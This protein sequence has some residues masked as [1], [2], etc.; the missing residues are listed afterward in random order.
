M[1]DRAAQDQRLVR[2]VLEGDT[3]AYGE[4][5]ARYQR[6]IAGVAWRYGA[7][8]NEIEDV[9]S[10][11]LIKAYDNLARYR[12][13][14]FTIEEAEELFGVILRSKRYTFIESGLTHPRF[15]ELF[16]EFVD[17]V[18]AVKSANFQILFLC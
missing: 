5:V 9:V 7:P 15:L 10:E 17:D 13:S 16:E 12:R 1:E 11:I 2:S 18:V 8:A 6:M 3:D 4:L 14:D